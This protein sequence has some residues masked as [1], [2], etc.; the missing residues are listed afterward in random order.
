MSKRAPSPLHSDSNRS[1]Q[2]AR[3][4]LAALLPILARP[5]AQPA[6]ACC[7]DSLAWARWPAR[8]SCPGSYASFRRWLGGLRHSAVRR[9]D[10]RRGKSASLPLAE[11]GI[12]RQRDGVDWNP[13]LPQR[14]RADHVA[15][16]L[17][18]R[19]L[20]VYIWF[21]KEGWQWAARP[22]A[23]WPRG[24]A[25]PSAAVFRR[26]AAGRAYSPSAGY[27]L[28]SQRF[29]LAPSV[30]EIKC[31]LRDDLRKDSENWGSA[32]SRADISG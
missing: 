32:S 1:V 7:W 24:S 13:R 25:F 29:E 9:H 21:Y 3:Q 4:L 18:A 28:T 31:G 16:S 12:V 14:S 23:R 22:G 8:R 2:L 26:S 27:R 10:F 6:M 5:M 19:T 30:S 11:S 20:S 17:R 15:A